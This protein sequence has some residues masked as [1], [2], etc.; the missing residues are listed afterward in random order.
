MH[1]E[2]RP[3]PLRQE[4]CQEGH[5]SEHTTTPPAT[6]E[7]RTSW[8]EQHPRMASSNDV[9]TS[10]P[11]VN[12]A[13]LPALAISPQAP[14]Q[15]SAN[16][17]KRENRRRNRRAMYEELQEL[18]L[19]SLHVWARPDGQVHPFYDKIMMHL[20]PNL[21]QNERY[22]YLVDHLVPRPRQPQ[23]V[24]GPVAP[25]QKKSSDTTLFHDTHGKCTSRE[26][27]PG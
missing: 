7:Q 10:G 13:V 24:N 14:R 5:Q 12:S 21:L 8:I 11:Q 16:Q 15:P 26:G 19:G 23:E 25:M 9:S 4:Q 18:V 17:R 1:Q 2:W 27:P 20:S 6:T 3:R 22:Q